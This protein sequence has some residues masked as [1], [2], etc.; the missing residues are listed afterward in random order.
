M[1]KNKESEESQALVFTGRTATALDSLPPAVKAALSRY[2]TREAVGVAP[3]WKPEKEGEF[4]IGQV[5]TEKSAG[6]F[7][8]TVLGMMTPE[9]PRS[10]WL[11]A[12]L[13]IKMGSDSTLVGK[14]FVIQFEG[15]LR[16][17]DNPAIKNDMRVYKVIEVME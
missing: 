16:K 1:A 5:V 9:G 8:G 11:N 4:L 13:R 2:R 7:N 15:W 17:A 3:T 12:D 10:V 6:K 14:N